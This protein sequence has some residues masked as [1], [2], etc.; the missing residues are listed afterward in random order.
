MSGWIGVIM[1]KTGSVCVPTMVV[2]EYTKDHIF[3][4]QRNI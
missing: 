2:N 1:V 4:L 3:E